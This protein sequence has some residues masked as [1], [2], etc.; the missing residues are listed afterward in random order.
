MYALLLLLAPIATS[1]EKPKAQPS[2]AESKPQVQ[3]AYFVKVDRIIINR[4]R[5]FTTDYDAWGRPIHKPT[6]VWWVSFWDDVRV[7]VL[8]VPKIQIDRGW[9]AMDTVQNISR[10]TGGWLVEN[11]NGINVI[12][13]ELTVIDSPFDW[14]AR[15]RGIYLPI[16][17]P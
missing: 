4:V 2:Q 3:A 17:K 9:W 7:S 1:A 16:R 5:S 11:R 10:C 12:A 14:E 15:N 13:K 8:P 6:E